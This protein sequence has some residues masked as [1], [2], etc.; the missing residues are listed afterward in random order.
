MIHKDGILYTLI[1]VEYGLLHHCP[2]IVRDTSMK[3]FNLPPHTRYA[4]VAIITLLVAS[5]NVVP[6]IILGI[7]L[8]S[9]GAAQGYDVWLRL[10]NRAKSSNVT[11]WRGVR[12][13]TPQSSQR[14]TWRDI[15]PQLLW[16]VLCITTLTTGIIMLLRVVGW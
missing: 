16:V 13:E 8:L 14:P 2:S 9:V 5:F 4:L 12:Y 11:Y 6:D 1:V 15:Q 7:A 3:K 10:Q